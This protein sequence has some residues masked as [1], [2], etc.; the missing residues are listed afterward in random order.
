MDTN[1]FY[2]NHARYILTLKP[3]K[4]QDFNW[5]TSWDEC[6]GFFEDG[7]YIVEYHVKG[8]LTRRLQFTAKQGQAIV[9]KNNAWIQ[10]TILN[11][12]GLAARIWDD[13]EPNKLRRRL[14]N[15]AERCTFTPEEKRKIVEEIGNFYQEVKNALT[16]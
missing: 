15:R 4:T 16:N 12:S 1:K 8:F 14:E 6:T 2:Q 11:R 9:L 5:Q 10:N 7:N 13:D 3:I